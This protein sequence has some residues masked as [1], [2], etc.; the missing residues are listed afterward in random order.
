EVPFELLRLLGAPDLPHAPQR[1]HVLARPGS[2]VVVEP[3]PNL[4]VAQRGRCGRPGR[5]RGRGDGRRGSRGDGRR[6]RHRDGHDPF[7]ARQGPA[8]GRYSNRADAPRCAPRPSTV[9]SYPTAGVSGSSRTRRTIGSPTD[10]SAPRVG[11]EGTSRAGGRSATEGAASVVG[12]SVV[13]GVVGATETGAVVGGAVGGVV[14]GGSVVGGVVAGGT[15]V[16]GGATTSSVHSAGET[17]RS[18]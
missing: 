3:A 10:V 6:L 17:A 1:V 12:G 4:I 18:S 14:A 2:C 16:D 13:R 9:Q 11:G 7:L 8:V 15:V 5:R